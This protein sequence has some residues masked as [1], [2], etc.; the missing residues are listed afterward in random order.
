[1]PSLR[2]LSTFRPWRMRDGER[3]L[4]HH[5]LT[6]GRVSRGEQHRED[7]SLRDGQRAEERCGE[8]RSHRDGQRE[9]EAEQTCRDAVLAPERPQ[10]D[11]RSVRERDDRERR[12]RQELDGFPGRGDTSTRSSACVPTSSPI[13]TKIIAGVTIVPSTRRDTTP[14]PINASET[15]ARAHSI[16][17]PRQDPLP[18]PPRHSGERVETLA[19]SDPPT[20]AATGG[21]GGGNDCGLRDRRGAGRDGLCDDRG[22]GDRVADDSDSSYASWS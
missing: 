2:P 21:D 20:A 22:L 10:I 3:R 6:Q 11:T 9:T 14:K 15:T 7:E 19:A 13:P 18:G 1:M 17:R 12:L 16:R 8:Q 4:G 5:R